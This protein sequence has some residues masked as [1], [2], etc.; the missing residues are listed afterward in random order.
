MT[1]RERKDIKWIVAAGIAAV[2]LV[3]LVMGWQAR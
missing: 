1:P 2:V 3:L